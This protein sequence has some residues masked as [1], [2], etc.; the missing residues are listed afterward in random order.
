MLKNFKKNASI[1]G[2]GRVAGKPTP[3]EVHTRWKRRELSKPTK[4]S[5]LFAIL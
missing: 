3:E 2:K 1:Y 4:I 5:S